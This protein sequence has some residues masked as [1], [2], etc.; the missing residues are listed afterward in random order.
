[1]EKLVRRC[2]IDI[3]FIQESKCE[4][5]GKSIMREIDGQTLTKVV[6][7]LARG[8]LVVS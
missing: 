1:M 6:A 8:R 7:S 3:L 4:G 5:D 2:K